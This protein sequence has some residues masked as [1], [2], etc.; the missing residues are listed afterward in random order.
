MKEM[1]CDLAP[2]DLLV[3][4]RTWKILRSI[5][6]GTQPQLHRGNGFGEFK[7]TV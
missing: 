5:G 6:R 4:G 3:R 7:E 2:E 1:G